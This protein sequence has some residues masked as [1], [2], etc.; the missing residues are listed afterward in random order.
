MYFA[1]SLGIG[2][3][4]SNRIFFIDSGLFN[5]GFIAPSFK[6]LSMT[7]RN[8]LSLSKKPSYISSISSKNLTIVILILS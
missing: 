4:V 6:E 1:F 2:R 5:N 3:G 8:Y 7:S